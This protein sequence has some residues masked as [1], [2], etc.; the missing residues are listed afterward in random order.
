[1]ILSMHLVAIVSLAIC[2]PLGIHGNEGDGGLM[3]V[4]A[5]ERLVSYDCLG[6][7]ESLRVRGRKNVTTQR[8]PS[9]RRPLHGFTL[10]EL[11]VVI[12]I[13]GILIAL[14]LPAVQAA[15][16]AARMLQCQNNLKQISL[17]ALDH[18]HING[19]LP[20]GGWGWR[21][22]GDPDSGFGRGQ[23]AGLFYNV[24]PY[25]EQQVLHDLQSGYTPLGA[26]QQAA[27]L[28]MC[29][30]PLAAFCC[31]TRRPAIVYPQR[32]HERERGDGECADAGQCLQRRGGLFPRRL[33][34]RRR[35]R[36][37]RVGDGPND[38]NNAANWASKPEGTAPA[39]GCF[40]DMHTTNGIVAQRSRV[41]MADITDGT[42]NT[43]LV[44]E[45]SLCPDHYFDGNT[46]GDNQTVYSGD[47]WDIA[48]WAA[49]ER[50]RRHGPSALPRHGRRRQLP[51]LRQRSRHRLQHGLVR[52]LGAD[53]QLYDRRHDPPPAGQPQ[54][55]PGD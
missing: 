32:P 3:K 21:W 52:R 2:S 27:A 55:R 35:N 33:R 36:G 43:Y 16:E 48:R 54:R 12:T 20:T 46:I 18:E 45:K 14:L 5:D 53:D 51:E 47:D 17:A 6:H 42:T 26:Q 22:V 13:I 19:W 40:W 28:Q 4:H 8:K 10:V 31:P 29:Q 30:T 34:R 1:M 11:L 39:T 25:M 49:I 44:G 24:L 7:S 37:H 38:W 15:R 50:H 41:K 9:F 23:P